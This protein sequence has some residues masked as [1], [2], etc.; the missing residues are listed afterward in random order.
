MWL[1]STAMTDSTGLQKSLQ[2]VLRY[3]LGIEFHHR[4]L[5][6]FRAL[7]FGRG[8]LQAFLSISPQMPW[9]WVLRSGLD[10]NKNPLGLDSTKCSTSNFLLKLASWP[11]HSFLT[12]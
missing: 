2:T 12:T 6:A 1:P 5:E 4:L 7:I 9:S 11:R 8:I 3:S 10:G